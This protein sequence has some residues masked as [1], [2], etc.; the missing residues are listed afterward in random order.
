MPVDVALWFGDQVEGEGKKESSYHLTT[1]MNEQIEMGIKI[2]KTVNA[3]LNLFVFGT[4]YHSGSIMDYEAIIAN[5]FGGHIDW[6]QKITFD[7]V[8]FQF[9]HALGK[10]TTPVGG[11]IALKKEIIWNVIEDYLY[12]QSPSADIIGRGHTHEYRLLDNDHSYG[13]SAPALKL[14]LPR[15]DRYAR[16]MRGWYSVGFLIID[17]INGIAR[18]PEKHFFKYKIHEGGYKDY[19]DFFRDDEQDGDPEGMAGQTGSESQQEGSGDSGTPF[20][21]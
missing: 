21:Y 18:L 9:S 13:F 1:N 11:D 4:P 15:W 2:V 16:K 10:S 12:A 19:A 20:P 7:G 17:I 5:E 14:G 8:R 6:E 3:P